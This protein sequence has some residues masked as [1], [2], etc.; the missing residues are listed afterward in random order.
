MIEVGDPLGGAAHLV[1]LQDINLES[2][3]S[4]AYA[5]LS[6]CWGLTTPTAMLTEEVLPKW[7][8][9]IELQTLPKTFLDAIRVAQ[10]LEIQYLWI[11]CMCIIQDNNADWQKEAANMAAIYQ[12]A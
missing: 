4:V 7:L 3:S 8:L 12:N 6:H 10:K 5:A 2:K 9:K 11:D 1:Q